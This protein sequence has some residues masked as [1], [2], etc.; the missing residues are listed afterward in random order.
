MQENMC[1]ISRDKASGMR[2]KQASL[3]DMQV[4]QQAECTNLV[5]VAIQRELALLT[6]PPVISPHP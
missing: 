3:A 6:S 2:N 5:G 1:L 4:Q